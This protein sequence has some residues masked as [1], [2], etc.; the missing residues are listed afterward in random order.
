[1]RL[2]RERL[3]EAA[4]RAA[5]SVVERN[6]AA[7]AREFIASG[8]RAVLVCVDT[9]QLPASFAGRSFDT[10]LLSDLPSTVDPCGEDGEF[11]TFVHSGPIFRAPMSCAWVE[12]VLREEAI[13]VRRPLASAVHSR[14]TPSAFVLRSWQPEDAAELAPI[15]MANDARLSPWTP[16]RATGVATVT[17]LETR[18]G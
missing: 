16:A 2:Y 7:L 17:E 18:L 5:V 1:V 3:V 9:T 13:C 6:T 8:F 15:L 14:C 12:T 4:D 10:A 11:H